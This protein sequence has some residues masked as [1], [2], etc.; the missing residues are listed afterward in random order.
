[1]KRL[2]CILLIDD[3]PADNFLHSMA[4]RELDCAD[5]IEVAVNG[6]HALELLTT[7]QADG[8]LLN[9]ELLLLDINMPIMNGWEFAVAYASL[10]LDQR[11]GALVMM[12]TTSLNPDDQARAAELEVVQR[13]ASKPLRAGDLQGMLD[14][15]FPGRFPIAA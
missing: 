2:S 9:P 12:L 11:S 4:I 10:P 13:F 14:E 8:S 15:H 1:M 3:N 5:R 7:P 6:K